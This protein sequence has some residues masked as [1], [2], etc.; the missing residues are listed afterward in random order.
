MLICH[1]ISLPKQSVYAFFIKK[2]PVAIFIY[3][4]TRRVESGSVCVTLSGRVEVL[5]QKIT[6][7]MITATNP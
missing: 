3:S 5:I 4:L 6:S 2:N 1:F 7:D